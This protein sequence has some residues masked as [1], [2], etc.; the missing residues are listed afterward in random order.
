MR[1]WW[2]R[3]RREQ[4]SPT[5]AEARDERLSAYLDGD[6]DAT[7][8]PA[9]QSQ[10]AADPELLS[11]LDGMRQVR[12]GLSHLG[13]EVRAPRSFALEAPPAPARLPRMELA[14]RL[15]AAVAALLFAAVLVGDAATGG[16]D[17]GGDAVAQPTLEAP[18]A[19]R[20]ELAPAPGDAREASDEGAE[21]GAE[22][23]ADDAAAPAAA[24]A[25]VPTVAALAAPPPQADGAV[26]PAEADAAPSPDAQA[27]PAAEP[28]PAGDERTDERTD[29]DGLR[30]LEVA[31]LVA[32]A[33]LALAAAAQWAARRRG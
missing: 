3:G 30:A 17:G 11:A 29:G 18:A 24:P 23:R 8:T 10:L 7:D 32:A 5:A 26:P 25:A 13:G 14:T 28:P 22:S 16:D 4:P 27:A 1:M 20:A 12:E 9:L 15:G 33:A 21:A 31:L 2:R 6:W 19:A